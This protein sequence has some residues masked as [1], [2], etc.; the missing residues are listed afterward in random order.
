[1]VPDSTGAHSTG[2]PVKFGKTADLIG[3]RVVTATPSNDVTVIRY[4]RAG[5]QSVASLQLFAP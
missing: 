3:F 2:L 5:D 1:L 4:W